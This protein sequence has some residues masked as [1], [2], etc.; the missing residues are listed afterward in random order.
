[1]LPEQST[2]VYTSAGSKEHV[3]LLLL[4][5]DVTG[6]AVELDDEDEEPEWQTTS[7]ISVWT[8]VV[9]PSNPARTC[10]QNCHD[11]EIISPV[12]AS[13]SRDSLVLKSF[14]WQ[15]MQEGRQCMGSML[16]AKRGL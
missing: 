15:R 6:A 1:M 5:L 11:E 2:T 7:R 16:V 3:L 13:N 8:S 9:S 10:K 14:H 12:Q 4:L